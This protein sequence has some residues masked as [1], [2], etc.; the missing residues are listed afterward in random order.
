MSRTSSGKADF[1]HIFIVSAGTSDSSD[2]GSTALRGGSLSESPSP[3][4]IAESEQALAGGHAAANSQC[5]AARPER[6]RTHG[7]KNCNCGITSVPDCYSFFLNP[8]SW[9]LQNPVL[10]VESGAAQTLRTA[11]T[12]YQKKNNKIKEIGAELPDSISVQ[13][14]TEVRVRGERASSYSVLRWDIPSRTEHVHLTISKKHKGC[15]WQSKVG[16]GVQKFPAKSATRQ[17]HM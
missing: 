9:N 7:P 6:G 11:F 8:S 12:H 15:A 17:Q 10:Q 5:R 4:R 13:S 3:G 16:A 14:R 1:G 2:G